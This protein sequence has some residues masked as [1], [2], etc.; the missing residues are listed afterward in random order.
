MDE[1]DTLIDTLKLAQL[2]SFLDYTLPPLDIEKDGDGLSKNT[3]FRKAMASLFIYL[4]NS[5][6]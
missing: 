1:L 2:K 3:R 5:T 4:E 6:H